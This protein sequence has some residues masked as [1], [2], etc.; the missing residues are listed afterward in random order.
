MIRN[1]A[2]K[3]FTLKDDNSK[4]EEK[5]SMF[6]FFNNSKS[7]KVAPTPTK[8]TPTTGGK[9]RTKKNRITKKRVQK[10]RPFKSRSKK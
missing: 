2:T 3:C 9:L 10:R 5:N 4:P 1:D 7:A 6:S 8:V